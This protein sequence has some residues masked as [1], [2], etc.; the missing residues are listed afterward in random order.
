MQTITTAFQLQFLFISNIFL[1]K[2]FWQDDEAVL[3]FYNSSF[4]YE[5]YNLFL[6]IS[7]IAGGSFNV[8]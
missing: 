2:I 6:N 8:S 7:G 5:Q 1:N 4:E 3:F